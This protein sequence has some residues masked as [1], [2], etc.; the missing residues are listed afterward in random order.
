[1]E[2]DDAVGEALAGGQAVGKAEAGSKEQSPSKPSIRTQRKSKEKGHEDDEKM[3][4]IIKIM[5]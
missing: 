4:P 2:V 5:V 3:S 1:M